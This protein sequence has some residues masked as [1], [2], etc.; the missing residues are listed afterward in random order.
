VAVLA[1]NIQGLIQVTNGTFSD[2]AGITSFNR[3]SLSTL[4]LSI[5]GTRTLRSLFIF[6]QFFGVWA[7]FKGL[8]M[9]RAVALSGSSP[10]GGGPSYLRA[11]T[12]IVFGG[13]AVNIY[14]WIDQVRNFFN[15]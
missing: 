4:N 14:F 7:V 12:H 9:G 2:G 10:G 13:I 15:L 8:Y 1:I 5:Q 11:G 3:S 6:L